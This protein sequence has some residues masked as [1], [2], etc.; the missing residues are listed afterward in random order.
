MT[1]RGCV[2]WMIACAI[3]FVFPA[4]IQ[5]RSVNFRFHTFPFQ[6]SYQCVVL[7]NDFLCLFQQCFVLS[8]EHSVDQSSDVSG[9]H[10]ISPI[11]AYWDS[12]SSIVLISS[13]SNSRKYPLPPLFT[14][15]IIFIWVSFG[16]PLGDAPGSKATGASLT[17]EK[18]LTCL[19]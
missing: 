1:F 14:V 17:K 2:A 9:I 10:V 13:L 7:F 5:K 15:I 16:F 3:N 8:A 18:R 6:F 11:S 12:H 19:F 4:T